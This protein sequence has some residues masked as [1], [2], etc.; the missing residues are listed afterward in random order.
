MHQVRGAPSLKLP[1]KTLA[2]PGAPESA[3]QPDKQP[4]RVSSPASLLDLL[5]AWPPI[6]LQSTWLLAEPFQAVAS[7]GPLSSCYGHR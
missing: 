4:S 3:G 2:V 6:P 1:V 5:A 7:V